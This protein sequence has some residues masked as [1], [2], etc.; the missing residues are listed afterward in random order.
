MYIRVFKTNSTVIDT[1]FETAESHC[2][3]LPWL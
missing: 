2:A 3:T 1:L